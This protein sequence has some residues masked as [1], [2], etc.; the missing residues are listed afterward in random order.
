MVG[1]RYSRLDAYQVSNEIIAFVIIDLEMTMYIFPNLKGGLFASFSALRMLDCPG[2]VCLAV[3]IPQIP[4]ATV[5]FG[6]QFQNG[7]GYI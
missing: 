1:P 4:D 2:T 3:V 7:N 5:P 6:R